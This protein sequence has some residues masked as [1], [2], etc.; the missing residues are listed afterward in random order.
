MATEDPLTP[1]VSFGLSGFAFVCGCVA[2]GSPS[3]ELVAA[4]VL[5]PA[6]TAV[7]LAP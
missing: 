3:L 5:L 1:A 7:A 2:L 6:A 4:G